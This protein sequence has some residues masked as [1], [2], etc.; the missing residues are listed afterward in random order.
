MAAQRRRRL[1][2]HGHIRAAP[3]D[4]RERLIRVL[5][6]R[7][8]VRE[9]Q[10]D[11]VRVRPRGRRHLGDGVRRR[12]RTQAVKMTLRSAFLCATVLAAAPAAWSQPYAFV[13]G[14]AA[15]A[16]GVVDV[17]SQSL[18]GSVP[19]SGLPSGVALSH[20]G[21]RLYVVRSQLDSLA[22]IDTSNGTIGSIPVGAAPTAVT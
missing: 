7:D 3:G 22:V 8:G 21:S 20:D 5:T 17:A 19:L 10:A 11:A 2:G 13:T 18:V 9:G 16:I 15:G 14:G 1:R 12:H 4:G 6:G